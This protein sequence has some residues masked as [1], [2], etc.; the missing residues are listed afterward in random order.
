MKDVRRTS[1]SQHS[2]DLKNPIDCEIS[3]YKKILNFGPLGA[4][5]ILYCKVDLTD[6]S[7]TLISE[8]IEVEKD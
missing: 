1:L 6:F 4:V 8:V 7:S 5:T 3:V 2:R